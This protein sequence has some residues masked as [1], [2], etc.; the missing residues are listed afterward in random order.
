MGDGLPQQQSRV[1][2]PLGVRSLPPP[3]GLRGVHQA[4][5]AE[6]EALRL[7]RAQRQR[8]ALTSL[9]AVAGLCAAALARISHPASSRDVARD[10]PRS[11]SKSKQSED[12]RNE[13][14]ST[15]DRGLATE[16]IREMRATS[17]TSRSGGIASRAS[18]QRRALPSGSASTCWLCSKPTRQHPGE[19]GGSER[20]RTRRCRVLSHHERS[21][22]GQHR[23]PNSLSRGPARKKPPS[24]Q[25]KN[26]PKNTTKSGHLSRQRKP[27]GWR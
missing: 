5:Q 1:E 24:T 16:A 10:R 8:S 7:S 3:V 18:L 4:G 21:L 23:S 6:P 26:Y 2:P 17:P 20:S 12:G 9:R 11:R 15:G 22:M 13:V 25:R 14:K 19:C 27:M